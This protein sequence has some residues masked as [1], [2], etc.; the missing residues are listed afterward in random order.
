MPFALAVLRRDGPSG[1][2]MRA[3]ASEAGI[4][5]TALYRHYPDKDALVQAIVRTV[6]GIFRQHLIGEVPGTDAAIWL[7]LAFDRFM[8]FGLEHPNYYRL[9]FVEPHGFGIDR[10]PY[11]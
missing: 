2:T 9:L 10:R 4:T 6:Y 3:V 8:R 11:V 5:A 1:L 7:R